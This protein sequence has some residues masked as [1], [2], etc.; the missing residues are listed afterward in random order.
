MMRGCTLLGLPLLSVLGALSMTPALAQSTPP[1]LEP[2]LIGQP[3]G[4]KTGGKS[5]DQPKLQEPPRPPAVPDLST[6]NAPA[7]PS[8]R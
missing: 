2:K 6:L 5:T 8:A 1:D 7:A 4:D 3:V